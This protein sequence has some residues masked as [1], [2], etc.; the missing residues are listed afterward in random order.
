MEEKITKSIHLLIENPS[1]EIVSFSEKLG[2]SAPVLCDDVKKI[3]D[4]D[5]DKVKLKVLITV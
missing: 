5:K 2:E 3:K 1:E 4:E